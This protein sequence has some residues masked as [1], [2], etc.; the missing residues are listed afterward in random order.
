MAHDE[1]YRLAE[2][3]IEEALKSGA[4]ELDLGQKYN[5][6]DEEKLTKLPDSLWQFTQL[7]KLNL[8][9]NQ[10]TALPEALGQLPQLQSLD[11][12]SN[13]LTALPEALGQ[14]PQ[15]HTLYLR[16]NNFTTLPES[17][18]QLTQ[19]HF[20]HIAGN[21]LNTL[22]E[23]VSSFKNLN[24]LFLGTLDGSINPM[25]EVPSVISR[26][27][28]LTELS[29]NCFSWTSIPE[30][31]GDLQN[32]EILWL[33]HNRLTDLP[34]SLAQLEHLESIHLDDNPLNPELAEAKEQGLDAVKTYLRARAEGEIVLNEAK[35]ILVGEG[36]VG[37][38]SL[39][40][41]LHGDEWVENRQTTYGME[42]DI[43]SLVLT[44]AVTSAEITFNGW[45]FG[46]QDIYRHTHQLFFTAPAVYLAVWEPRRGPEQSRVSE[47][48]K[49]IK[50]R[51][52]EESRPDL[53]PRVLVVAT[54]GGPKERLAHIDE[55]ALRDEFGDMIAGFFHVDSKPDE[56]GICYQL[57][58]LKNAIA[59][60]AAS[61]PSVRRSV[62]LSWKKVL[63]A[64]RKRSA[65]DPYISYS[66]YEAL[67]NRQGV[68]KNL[69]G[70]Y[71]IILNELGYLIHYRNDETLKDTVILKPDYL[72]KAVSFILD[73]KATKEANGLIEHRRLG[74]IWDN[75][76]RPARER[77]P[78]KLHPI[79]LK[80]M[81]RFDLSYQ[82]NMPEVEAPPTS[83]MAQLVPGVRPEGWEKD[84]VLK[85]GD[86]EHTQV[87]RILDAQTGRTEEAE[88]LMYRLIVR[89]HRYSLGRKDY[90]KSRHWK[91]GLIL[92]DGYNG[93]AFIEDIDGDIYVTVRAAYPER[94]L[95][96][97]CTEVQWLVKNFW[98]GLDARLFVPCVTAK[99][100]GLLEIDEI[101]DYKA[102]GAT[103]VR[104]SVCRQFIEIDSLM[105][106][107]QPK[108][109]WDEAVAILR[110]E[111]RQI[112][113]AQDIGFERLSTQLRV[114]M[115]R[116]DE[117]YENLL[118]WLSDPAKEGPRLFSFEPVNR[119][120]FD[121]A[122]WTHETFRLVLWC[123][124]ARVPLPLLN[125]QNSKKG[126]Y[127]I[128][129]SHEWFKKAAPMLKSI[130]TIASLVLP[131]ASAGMKLVINESL[132]NNLDFAKETIDA[133]L[134]GFEKS[135]DRLA[136]SGESG[137]AKDFRPDDS[138][139][140]ELHA[141]LKAKDPSFGGLVRVMNKRHEFL[142]VHER[143]ASEY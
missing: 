99:C 38:T 75:P 92:D 29:L 46:G 130:T 64:V 110:N 85:P 9:H 69:A 140:R 111:H 79:F 63:S 86:G 90:S 118:V 50:H 60:E 132:Y 66:Q 82:V 135:V 48:I 19:L 57:D 56:N 98:K 61:I 74:E 70:L 34:P 119:S 137:I 6:K 39:L 20:L 25:E 22:P 67:C 32:L 81:E 102:N 124:H 123:E 80:L 41:A 95:H 71:A 125:G 68:P 87:C 96:Q 35:L 141:F 107:M 47:W 15:L 126:V 23:F 30:W 133:S 89:L 40:T 112:L 65:R 134:T 142:W 129:L 42:V 78:G 28:K 73:D 109:V 76:A 106:T 121:P 44:D 7:Q 101:M 72:S 115:S 138:A 16:N 2:K 52:Y 10:L 8:S 84:W 45:D 17:I 128:D 136:Q 113:Q 114:L 3:K 31:L 54:H 26:L 49:I 36:G 11:L 77:Y 97:L 27:N 104:C 18:G 5:A 131:I 24:E 83:L 13:Q 53:R 127:E 105:A 88:G 100:K 139:L 37:K 33:S 143:F 55:Q 4:T 116:S 43:T 120:R 103:K 58:E 51:A 59:R 62:P 14:L 93:R 108:P 122:N 117:Q 94:F 21:Q 91:T 12:S 1:A